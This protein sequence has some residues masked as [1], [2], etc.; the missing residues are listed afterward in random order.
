MN[1]LVYTDAAYTEVGVIQRYTLDLAFGVDENDFE[2]KTGADMLLQPGALVYVEGTEWGG[3]VDSVQVDETGEVPEVTNR[4]RTW[5]GILAGKVLCP[6]SGESHYTYDCDA[7]ALLAEVIERCGLGAVFEASAGASA[8]VSGEFDRYT[9]AYSGLKKELAANGLRL[10]IE[11]VPAGKTLLS[12][13]PVR[14]YSEEMYSDQMAMDVTLD[15]RPVNHLVCLGSGELAARQVVHLYAD[16]DGAVSTT[17]TLFGAAERA[18]VYDYSG[19]SDLT[20]D[21]TKKLKEL[22]G[23]GTEIDLDLPDGG[24]YHIGDTIGCTSV[25]T[26]IAVTATV[27]KLI[28]KVGEDRV[29]IVSYEVGNLNGSDAKDY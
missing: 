10:G 22:Q 13:V 24:G 20:A 28:V 15:Y 21:G 6:D 23:E 29:P 12:A 11:R 18:E 7:N 8:A 2:L 19:S 4:G 3:I 5:H 26:G 17:Q 1:D 27:N 16:I 25:T 9:D 14:D